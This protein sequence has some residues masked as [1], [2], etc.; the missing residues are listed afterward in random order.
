MLGGHISWTDYRPA[1][2]PDAVRIVHHKTGE[3]VWLS[4]SDEDG[5]LSRQNREQVSD[6]SQNGVAAAKSE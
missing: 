1:E 6:E 2:R 3:L 5:P 4:L